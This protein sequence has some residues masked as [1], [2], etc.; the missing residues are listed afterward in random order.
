MLAIG[1]KQ[2]RL[3]PVRL[4]TIFYGISRGTAIKD[5]YAFGG[6]MI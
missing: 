2:I 6:K 1:K 5:W 3:I 4:D